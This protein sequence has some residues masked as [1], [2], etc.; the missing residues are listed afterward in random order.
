MCAVRAII[1]IAIVAYLGVF[2]PIDH[3]VQGLLLI[4]ILLYGLLKSIVWIARLFERQ[5]DISG[6]PVIRRDK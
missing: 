3:W 1:I 6:D 5:T 4:S 2:A